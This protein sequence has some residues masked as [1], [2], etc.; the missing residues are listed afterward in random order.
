M[1]KVRAG[2]AGEVQAN[3]GKSRPK[4]RGHKLAATIVVERGLD[5][6]GWWP[7]GVNTP[8]DGADE[9]NGLGL[10]NGMADAVAAIRARWTGDRCSSNKAQVENDGAVRAG[11]ASGLE[12]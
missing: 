7:P 1:T 6:V 3:A 2:C 12:P 9:G 5:D 11:D 4:G 10:G 8:G